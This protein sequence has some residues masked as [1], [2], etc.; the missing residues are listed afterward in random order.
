MI[1]EMYKRFK[2]SPKMAWISNE[3]WK[4]ISTLKTTENCNWNCHGGLNSFLST[5]PWYTLDN[6]IHQDCLLY[7]V[8]ST[9]ALHF[10]AIVYVVSIR[11]TATSRTILYKYDEKHARLHMYRI[12]KERWGMVGLV[13]INII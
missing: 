2:S 12:C 4:Y 13:S 6:P 10:L 5:L 9:G 7:N 1:E 11:T 3:R 8:D